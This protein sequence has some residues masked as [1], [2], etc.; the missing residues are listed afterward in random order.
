MPEI[1]PVRITSAL[2]EPPESRSG[3]IS[4]EERTVSNSS[5][6]T[7]VSSS[8]RGFL[9]ADGDCGGWFWYLLAILARFCS[10]EPP[11]AAECVAAASVWACD[12]SRSSIW[13]FLLSSDSGLAS[14]LDR[15]VAG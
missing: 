13:S 5:L 3:S 6:S 11:S 1:S 7:E 4:N 9:A 12:R 15:S 2:L 10:A 8:V 14:F